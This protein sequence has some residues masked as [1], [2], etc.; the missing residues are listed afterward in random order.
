M[1]AEQIIIE[2]GAERLGEVAEMGH[3][4]YQ[5]GALPGSVKPDVFIRTW[6]ALLASGAAVLFGLEIGG[7]LVGVL[8]G[9]EYPD[10]NDGDRVATEMF[11]F[12]TPS[13]RGGGLRLLDTFEAWAKQRGVRRILMMHL[14][15]LKSAAFERL[16]QRRGYRPIEIHYCKELN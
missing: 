5:E 3:G 7:R 14:H 8:G 11:W 16:Y 15:A 2:V 12:V 13:A 1:N 4:F 6:T 9:L 10:P